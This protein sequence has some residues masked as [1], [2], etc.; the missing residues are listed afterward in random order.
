MQWIRIVA[1]LL[2]LLSIGLSN[3]Q[4]VETVSARFCISK[5]EIEKWL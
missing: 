3:E 4:V 2:E 1:L 5:E